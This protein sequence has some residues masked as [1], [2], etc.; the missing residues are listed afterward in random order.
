MVRRRR[1]RIVG[2]GLDAEA[3]L[4]WP[5]TSPKWAPAE[6]WKWP[7]VLC[8]GHGHHTPNPAPTTV[9]GG[10]KRGPAV[11]PFA[12]KKMTA[13]RTI[14]PKI[15]NNDKND[16]LVGQNNSGRDGGGGPY[17]NHAAAVTTTSTTVTTDNCATAADFSSSSSFSFGSL[18][19]PQS[20]CPGQA[21][22]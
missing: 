18:A 2:V 11:G 1:R 12:K 19:R 5:T 16:V 3:R 17:P 8:V 14:K 20:A 4:I 10:D 7:G 15:T 13:R 6:D 21:K 22:N 9:L